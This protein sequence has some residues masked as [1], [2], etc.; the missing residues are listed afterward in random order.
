VN[1]LIATDGSDVAIEAARSGLTLFGGDVNIT[2]VTVVPPEEDPM[3]M[4]GGFEGPLFTPQETR[5]MHQHDLER[6]ELAIERTERVVG[7]TTV[8]DVVSAGDT[9][10]AICAEAIRHHADVIVMGDSEKGWFRRL[11]EGSEMD[12]VVRHA[13]CPVLVVP[14]RHRGD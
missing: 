14:R 3:A 10:Y 1:V 12:H 11:L 8:H 2:L 6:G 4:A 7:T 5:E 9:A 13:P